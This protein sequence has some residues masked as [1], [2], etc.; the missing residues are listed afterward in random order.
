MRPSPRITGGLKTFRTKKYAVG[1]AIKTPM[2]VKS[3]IPCR[4]SMGFEHRS[5]KSSVA[6]TFTRQSVPLVA[7]ANAT[8]L[9]GNFPGGSRVQS[10]YTAADLGVAGAITQVSWGPS[11][12][13]VFAATHP[14]VTLRMAHST[15]TSLQTSFAANLNLGPTVLGYSGPYAIPAVKNVR[16]ANPQNANGISPDLTNTG[17]RN[18]TGFWAWP[19]F[20]EPFEYDGTNNV[21]FDAAVQPAGNCQIQRGVFVGAGAAFGSRRA[22]ASN[23]NSG[24]AD[25]AVDAVIYDMAFDKRRRTT[26]AVSRWYALPGGSPVYGKPIVSPS[27]QAAGVEVIVEMEAAHAQA[28]PLDPTRLVPR[29]GTS[30]G[31]TS[32]PE[33]LE[34]R[35]L[36]RFRVTMVANLTT[37]QTA[38]IES[39]QFPYRF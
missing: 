39:I 34:G 33:A 17:A 10:L 24:S 2:L 28:D 26:R 8:C 37:N 35:T 13:N 14:G 36:F 27:G 16:P 25:F 12:N 23:V 11:S 19:A 1:V 21:I 4:V 20:T 5:R 32:I 38:E 9:A 18:A 7:T 15:L 29:P 22:V 6:A 3:L 31:W 30:T